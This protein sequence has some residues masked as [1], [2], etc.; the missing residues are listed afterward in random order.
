[1]DNVKLILVLIVLLLEV[2]ACAK[3]GEK[4]P[5]ACTAYPSAYEVEFPDSS[6]R[7]ASVENCGDTFKATD[8]GQGAAVIESSALTIQLKDEKTGIPY[9]TTFAGQ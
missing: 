1:M 6:I 2:V 7:K 5:E 3:K 4:A 8:L 9:L